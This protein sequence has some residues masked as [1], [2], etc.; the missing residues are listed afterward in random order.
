MYL[1]ENLKKSR[2][3]CF[4]YDLSHGIEKSRFG[5]MGKIVRADNISFDKTRAIFS[6]EGLHGYKYPNDA[7]SVGSYLGLLYYN[8]PNGFF[9]SGEKKGNLSTGKKSFVNFGGGVFIFPDCKFYNIITDEL[10]YLY[11]QI[12]ADIK[13]VPNDTNWCK[14]YYS[15]S[16]GNLASDL[17]DYGS[18]AIIGSIN[19]IYDGNYKIEKYDFTNGSIYFKHVNFE[20]QPVNNQT[21]TITNKIPALEG[22][23]ICKNRIFGFAENKIYASAQDNGLSW[24]DFDSDDG[25]YFYQNMG[26]EYFV[27]CDSLEDQAIFF[28]KNKI[29][30]IYGNDAREFSLKVVSEYC[31]LDV[32]FG[33]SCAKVRGNL[34]FINKSSIVKFNGINCE[35]VCRL[36]EKN[37]ASVKCQGFNDKLYLYYVSDSGQHF[38]VLDIDTGAVSHIGIKDVVGFFRIEDYVCVMT[39]GEVI[40]LD[41]NENALDLKYLPE[42]KVSSCI[43]FDEIYNGTEKI[44]PMKLRM[45]AKIMR[46]GRLDIYCMFENSGEWIYVGKIDEERKRLFTFHLPCLITDSFK[47][48]ISGSGGYEITNIDVVLQ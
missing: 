16:G 9:V 37:I 47:L 1:S 5:N 36:D 4:S 3:Q 40:V 43:E 6:R 48:K 41:G 31:G 33:G 29:Y 44:S 19:G 32:D 22:A 7:I 14:A 20:N 42:G 34:Y 11:K 25:S 13:I 18:I 28:T 10:D 30:K 21:I 35:E 15:L 26:G 8:T 27:A 12:S 24:L 17:A 39:R 2:E 46:G 38:C 23:C 45:R